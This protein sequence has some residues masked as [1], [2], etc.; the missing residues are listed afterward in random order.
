ML[1]F[2]LGLILG[3]FLGMLV[4]GIFAARNKSEMMFSDE[5]AVYKK[6][7]DEYLETAE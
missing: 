3:G 5:E 6:Y 4:M 7:V 1:W 2:A